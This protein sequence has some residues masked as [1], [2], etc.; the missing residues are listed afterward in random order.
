MNQNTSSELLDMLAGDSH[1]GTRATVAANP[2]T[3]SEPLK[4]LTVDG[5]PQVRQEAAHGLRRRLSSR[6]AA[7]ATPGV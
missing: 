6:R 7:A 5:Q 2:N 1:I 3:S 4:V